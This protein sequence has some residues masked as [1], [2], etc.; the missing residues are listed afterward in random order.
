MDARPDAA[1]GR[2]ALLIAADTFE[3]P[4][5]TRLVGPQNDVDALAD[6]L[7]DPRIGGF[8]VH[9][10]VNQPSHVVRRELA[11]FLQRRA[12]H[13]LALVY[14]SGHGIVDA[15][16]GDLHFATTDTEPDLLSATALSAGFVRD[17]M[18]SARPH[19]TV[20]VLDCCNS[21]MYA[22]GMTAKAGGSVQAGDRLTGRGRTIL[23]ASDV[24]QY[25][26]DGTD[27]AGTGRRSVFT[28][29]LV[30]GLASGRADLNGD[31]EVDLDE[32]YAYV[33]EQ[34]AA[35]GAKQQ[36]RRWV[37]ATGRIVI[38]TSPRG[39]TSALPPDIDVH[40]HSSF[41]GVRLAAVAELGRLLGDPTTAADALV[42]LRRIADDTDTAMSAAAAA[43]IGPTPQAE[44][45]AGP[46]ATV[47]KPRTKRAL[48]AE[49]AVTKPTAAAKPAA[50]KP[51]TQKERAAEVD[52][53][54]PQLIAIPRTTL[55]HPVPN[56][57]TANDR[58]M[59]WAFLDRPKPTFKVARTTV[60]AFQVTRPVTNGEYSAF[61]EAT[62][63]NT[64]P[65]HWG[66]RRPP[67]AIRSEP[68]FWVSCAA[69]H[70]Y[71]MWL[72]HRLGVAYRLPTTD[73]YE[74]LEQ[75][76]RW[77]DLLLPSGRREWAV[78][79]GDPAPTVVVSQL[80]Q[81]ATTSLILQLKSG[82]RAASIGFRL[83]VSPVE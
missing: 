3:H 24:L 75:D 45:A 34:V 12:R 13:D 43:L 6:V 5:I 11:R 39:R 30:D 73:E 60:Q 32:L 77:H 1:P 42:R 29:I 55:Y 65:Q 72:G 66:R 54:A 56:A 68:E 14:Y 69:A 7:G 36:P 18:D 49:P 83:A 82:V 53:A 79:P 64:W 78:K 15:A 40:L 20:V 4:E 17:R 57:D 52:V 28:R 81:V 46:P 76:E 74:V 2:F 50:A 80:G 67:D 47:A 37:D 16:G 61:V 33:D 25:A 35:A 59:R 38:A 31:G 23:T 70:Q 41:A 26:W 44:S 71:Y 27:V 19:T 62:G 48:T 22:R 63:R 9:R 51:R 10:V 58:R 8:D 21:G